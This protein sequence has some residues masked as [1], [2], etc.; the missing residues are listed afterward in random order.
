MAFNLLAM[1][2]NLE[3]VASNLEAMASK[4]IAMTPRRYNAVNTTSLKAATPPRI[5]IVV[6]PNLIY[7]YSCL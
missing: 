5:Y 6:A 2:S 3:A 1:A 4:L 7:Y